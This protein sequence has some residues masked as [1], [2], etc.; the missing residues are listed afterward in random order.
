MVNE[1]KKLKIEKV[2]SSLEISILDRIKSATSEKNK[3]LGRIIWESDQKKINMAE[4]TGEEPCL[5]FQPGKL[6]IMFE[7]FGRKYNCG[8]CSGYQIY[9]KGYTPIGEI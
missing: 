3:C 5:T 6:A 8:N 2:G 7:G 9:C 1:R 4:K